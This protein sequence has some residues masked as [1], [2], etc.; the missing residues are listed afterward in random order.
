MP[1]PSALTPPAPVSHNAKKAAEQVRVGQEEEVEGGVE[2]RKRA[3]RGTHF[4]WQAQVG[5]EKRRWAKI[6]LGREGVLRRKREEV[7]VLRF[8]H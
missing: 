8:G 6:R 3:K 2:G 1:S 4:R 7:V 5:R